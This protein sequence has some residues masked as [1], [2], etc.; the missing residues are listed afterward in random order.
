[1]S[2]GETLE[3]TGIRPISDRHLR[4]M[5]ATRINA[6]RT[7]RD[8]K[9]RGVISRDDDPKDIA[10]AIAVEIAANNA[11]EFEKCAGEDGRDW[12]SFFKALVEF[13]TAIMP[14]IMMFM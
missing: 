8:L 5:G 1:M 7:A 9:R 11:E 13:F 14:I 2:T 6:L 4:R 12:P 3:T 10:T